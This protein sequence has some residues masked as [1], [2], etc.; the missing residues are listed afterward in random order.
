MKVKFFLLLLFVKYNFI[1]DTKAQEYLV[2]DLQ[3]YSKENIN[4]HFDD[5]DFFRLAIDRIY[6]NIII[7]I[8]IKYE[9]TEN[10][11]DEFG[12]NSPCSDYAVIYLNDKFR[13]YPSDKDIHFDENYI[14]TSLS[15]DY[16]YKN[17]YSSNDFNKYYIIS[18]QY[19]IGKIV[20]DMYFY[21][22]LKIQNLFNDGNC[23]YIIEITKAEEEKKKKPN[24]K[25]LLI[26]SSIIA[27][28]ALII[29][30]AALCVKEWKKKYNVERTDI[31]ENPNLLPE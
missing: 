24:Y 21:I 8:K 17:V 7:D 22:G 4:E 30:I 31:P 10:N 23:S 20:N 13:E 1:L 3:L 2:T 26:I 25:L 12:K 19:K 14:I 9:I 5:Y 11:K 27:G 15:C 16:E 18:T 6:Q 29:L 28:L